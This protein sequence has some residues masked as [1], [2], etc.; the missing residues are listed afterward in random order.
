MIFTRIPTHRANED[1]FLKKDKGRFRKLVKE[2]EKTGTHKICGIVIVNVPDKVK[3]K[4]RKF[5][6]LKLETEGLKIERLQRQKPSQISEFVY[7]TNRPEDDPSDPI[8]VKEKYNWDSWKSS[9]HS[10]GHLTK[11]NFWEFFKNLA[12]DQEDVVYPAGIDG[13]LIDEGN[14]VGRF[15]GHVVILSFGDFMVMR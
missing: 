13:T 1:L 6:T 7:D 3:K 15:Y 2:I 4:A 12:I 5:V 8:T 10:Q 11:D 14:F 9:K